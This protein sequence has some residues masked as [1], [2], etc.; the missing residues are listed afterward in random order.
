MG[1]R[2]V[3]VTT[4]NQ[5]SRAYELVESSFLSMTSLVGTTASEEMSG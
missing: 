4:R 5:A 2:R 3:V 1:A